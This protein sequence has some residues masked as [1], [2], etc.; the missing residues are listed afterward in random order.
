MEFFCDYDM[1][2]Y[3]FDA[4]TCYMILKLEGGVEK[5]L[6]LTP[7]QLEY[8]GPTEL[9]QYYVKKYSLGKSASDDIKGL[10]ISIM[11]GRRLLGTFLTI[12]FPTVLL[13]I[14]GH[15]TNFFNPFFFEAVVT[16]NLTGKS[17]SCNTT[18]S[19]AGPNHHIHQC[20]QQ[21][22]EDILRQ[23]GGHL[24]DLQPP[25]A[26]HRSGD[27][28]VHGFPQVCLMDLPSCHQE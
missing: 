17:H 2:W 27:P 25:P 13:N 7:G 21:L 6:S 19:Y 11:F 14:I 22:T 10:K 9:T 8:L 23:D 4:Q 26:L 5:L 12:F 20:V 1:Q 18:F 24:A 15:A 16:V 3:P 28:H